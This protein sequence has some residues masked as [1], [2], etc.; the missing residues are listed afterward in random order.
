MTYFGSLFIIS[1][2]S[3]A[4]KTS[5]VNSIV[6]KINNI[7][8]SISYTTRDKRP[9]EQNGVDYFF[10][11][12]ETFLTM[13]HNGEF[14]E[15]AQVFDNYYA[16]SKSMVQQILA[17]GKD[18]ILEIDW[19]GAKQIKKEVIN[20]SANTKGQSIHSLSI[21]ILPPSLKILSDR[22]VARGQDK[23]EII[24]KRLNAAQKETRHYV[25]Y[26]YLV[27][28][29][30]FDHAIEDLAAIINAHRLTINRQKV[31]YSALI[32]SLLV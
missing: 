3:G 19:Q 9:D 12:K 14:L 32:N 7:E 2:A 17:S 15:S 11:N 23:I 16:T 24:H 1:A 26:D 8:L 21:F 30:D 31:V 18:I 4:G 22:L 10:V 25:Y 29:D 6:K 27:I 13:K 28:N 20:W 5:L